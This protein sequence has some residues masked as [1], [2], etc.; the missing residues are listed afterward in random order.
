MELNIDGQLF[1][2]CGASSGF[3]RAVTQT[4]L[5]EHARVIAVARRKEKLEDLRSAAPDQCEIITGD[6]SRE[7]TLE[8]IEHQV[9]D[10]NLTGLTLNSGGPPT[11]SAEHTTAE[12]WDAAYHSVFRWKTRLTGRLLPKMKAQN[13]GRILFIESASIKQ[14]I[15]NLAQSNVMR[16]A[17]A[18]YVKT[19]SHEIASHGVTANILAPGSHDTPAI[20]R[21]IESRKKDWNCSYDQARATM[22]KNVPVGRFGKAEELASLA[23]WLLSDKSGYVTGQVISHDGGNISG[24]FG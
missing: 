9:G 4:L 14:P 22:E 5:D 24:L 15:P 11:G 6:L 16:A 7:D 2:V 1:V 8:E 18:G 10:R 23:A 21:V 19:L 20:E 13:Y 12:Q 3:G 17:I